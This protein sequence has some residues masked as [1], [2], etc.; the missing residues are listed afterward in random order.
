MAQ[1]RKK[2]LLEYTLIWK[3]FPIWGK[4]CAADSFNRCGS[5][6]R[7][8]W[9]L[10]MNHFVQT[11]LVEVEFSSRDKRFKRNNEPAQQRRKNKVVPTNHKIGLQTSKC[12]GD[13]LYREFYRCAPY[14]RNKEETWATSVCQK[15]SL[16]FRRRMELA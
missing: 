8:C 10:S 1:V 15:A 11:G 16:Q 3:M 5:L 6:V 14:T 12:W 13:Y 7:L 9:F 2:E 4:I